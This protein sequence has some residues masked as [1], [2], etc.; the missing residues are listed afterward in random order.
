MIYFIM[1]GDLVK[2]GYSNNPK[3][4][5]AALSTGCPF[6][7]HLIGVTEGGPSEEAALHKAFAHLREK[8]EW[9][10]FDVEV[11]NHIRQHAIPYPIKAEK[12][13]PT[14]ALG[15]FLKEM[16]KTD[17][18]FASE[19]GCSQPQINRLRRGKAFPSP[20]MVVK[21]HVATQGAVTVEDWYSLP[22]VSKRK[23]SAEVAA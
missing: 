14:S 3:K 6:P 16:G 22:K 10:R 4:R 9:F 1:S 23:A 17:E 5:F 19:I 13:E 2:I 18:A 7:C 21:I 20:E 8:G 15:S 12:P 11:N